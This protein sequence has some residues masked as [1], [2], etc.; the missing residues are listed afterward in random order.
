MKFFSWL[1]RQ[2]AAPDGYVPR[3]VSEIPE[4]DRLTGD[5]LD[6]V[7][8]F[9][10]IPVRLTDGSRASMGNHVMRRKLSDGSWQYRSPAKDEAADFDSSMRW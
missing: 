2:P 7:V 9:W 10:Y 8:P 4:A 1:F 3:T 6:F 5:W